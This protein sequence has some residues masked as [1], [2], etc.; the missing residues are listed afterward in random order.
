[1]KKRLYRCTKESEES[2]AQGSGGLVHQV[3]IVRIGPFKAINAHTTTLWQIKDDTMLT[4]GSISV[5]FGA[6]FTLYIKM[7][8]STR[9]IRVCILLCTLGNVTRNKF[10]RSPIVDGPVR[11]RQ[12]NIIL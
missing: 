12:E 3:L 1:M 6:G 7:L 11:R 10:P 5:S 4:V 2:C 8:V 9:W